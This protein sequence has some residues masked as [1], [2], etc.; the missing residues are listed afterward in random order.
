M[1][2]T[3]KP[4]LVPW[5]FSEVA[6]NAFLFAVNFSKTLG[7][8][9]LL[10]HIVH[11]EKEISEK[12]IKLKATVEELSKEADKKP[13]CMVKS[14]SI[15]HAIGEVASEQKAEMII[16]GTHG[17]KGAQKLFGSKAV[18]VVVSS[19]IP[20]LL[21]Q[22]KPKR[23]KVESILLPIDFKKENK[24]KANWIYHLSTRFEAKVTIFKSHPK[25]KGFKRN[26]S[27]NMKYIESFL[28]T[29]D[30]EYYIVASSGK[31]SFKKEVVDYAKENDFDIILIMATRDIKITDYLFGAPEQ[32]I[33]AN[34]HNLPIMCINPR[35]MKIAS[36]FRAAGG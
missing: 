12:E 25:D 17:L 26:L 19:R 16:M 31:K 13:L 23:D 5:D 6:H 36:G 2:S 35:P 8:D 14:G 27:S 15:F 29:R 22:D 34:E 20:F 21:V 33:I 18:K 10:L 24:Q 3:G 32:Y 28:K 11:D 30:V 7:S 1:E 4:I 9:I